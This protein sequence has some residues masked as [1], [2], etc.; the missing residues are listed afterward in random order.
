MK[1]IQKGNSKISSMYMFNLPATIDICGRICK[2]CYAIKEQVRFPAVM[3]ARDRRYQ[4]S[5]LPTFGTDI[6][7]EIQ[8]LKNPPK[9]FRIHASGDFYSQEYVDHWS[10]I[11]RANPHIVFYAYTKRM[12][13]LDFSGLSILPNFVLINSLIGKKLN[14]GKLE[15]APK[16]MFVCPAHDKTVKCGETCT[17]CMTKGKADLNGVFFVQH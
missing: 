10:A 1:L 16:G 3:E 15:K 5:T 7:N 6:T 14:Y 11:A 13:K 4:A 2:G 12:G 17:Y 9:Y 8:K